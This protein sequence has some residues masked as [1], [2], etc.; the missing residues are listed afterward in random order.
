MGER[1]GARQFICYNTVLFFF[2]FLLQ[3]PGV[4]WITA[5]SQFYYVRLSLSVCTQTPLRQLYLKIKQLRLSR[6]LFSIGNSNFFDYRSASSKCQQWVGRRKFMVDSIGSPFLMAPPS[7]LLLF[8]RHFIVQLERVCILIVLLYRNIYNEFELRIF[9][10]VSA[11]CSPVEPIRRC[12]EVSQESRNLTEEELQWPLSCVSRNL[13]SGSRK[14]THQSFSGFAF[15][16]KLD[17]WGPMES[18]VYSS[19]G[20]NVWL[21]ESMM[22][23]F[24]RCWDCYDLNYLLINYITFTK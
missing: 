20:S 22:D 6:F 16:W 4:L 12:F 10:R 14:I 15:N 19:G 2:F 23:N 9:S 13:F 3:V 5:N 11:W 7:P 8:F 21:Q 18:G 1:T 17:L 24:A